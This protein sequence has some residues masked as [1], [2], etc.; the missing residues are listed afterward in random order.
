MIRVTIF[1]EKNLVT[2]TRE[3]KREKKCL[4]CLIISCCFGPKK[5]WAKRREWSEMKKIHLSKKLSNYQHVSRRTHKR[6][7]ADGWSFTK[8]VCEY[9]VALGDNVIILIDQMRALCGERSDFVGVIL[10]L[11]WSLWNEEKRK[12]NTTTMLFLISTLI[13]SHNPKSMRERLDN[14]LTLWTQN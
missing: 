7:K 8:Y 10:V 1:S 3:Y 9:Y 4:S 2:I 6:F 12:N 14:L 5:H 11:Q 13:A